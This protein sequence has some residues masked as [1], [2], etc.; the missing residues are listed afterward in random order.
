MGRIDPNTIFDWTGQNP[1]NDDREISGTGMIRGS[2]GAGC[3]QRVGRGVGRARSL[4]KAVCMITVAVS[5]VAFLGIHTRRISG[6]LSR[7]KLKMNL[8]LVLGSAAARSAPFDGSVGLVDSQAPSLI[9]NAADSSAPPLLRVFQVYPPVLTISP[10]DTL[11]LMDGEYSIDGSVALA[12]TKTTA[13]SQ[14]L[15]VHSFAYS[16]GQPY[17]GVSFVKTIKARMKR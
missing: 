12:N 13:C 4:V 3:S 16:Y 11:D 15:V 9:K 5:L 1:A 7:L 10:G 8:D 14:T 6:D 2:K 17:I